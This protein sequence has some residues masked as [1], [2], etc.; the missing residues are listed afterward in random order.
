MKL[1]VKFCAAILLLLSAIMGGTAWLLIRHE[2]QAIHEEVRTRAQ[3]VLS[4]GESCR[5]YTRD[6]LSKAVRQALPSPASAL[7]FE[8]E[9]A[10]VVD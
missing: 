10:L 8:A 3:T 4:F 9:S 2:H 6:V 1:R 5:A 7:V